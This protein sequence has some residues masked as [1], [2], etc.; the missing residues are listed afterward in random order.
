MA[1]QKNIITESGLEIVDAYVKIDVLTY[2]NSEKT[3][4]ISV[5][6]YSDKSFSDESKP[7][8]ERL[9]YKASLDANLNQLTQAYNYLKSLPEFEGAIDILE[10]D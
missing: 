8:V 5:N 1:I 9:Y 6:I 2:D 7:F 10:Y 3:A 4:S